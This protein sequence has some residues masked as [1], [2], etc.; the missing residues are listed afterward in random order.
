M[1]LFDEAK[2]T[3]HLFTANTSYVCRIL[4]SGHLGHV[5]YG[6][7][8]ADPVDP[9]ALEI[10]HRI[11]V[12][13][14]IVYDEADRS[15]NLNLARLEIS[16]YGKGDYRDPMVH[17]Q[18][19]DGSRITDF[20]VVGHEILADKPSFPGLPE[21]DAGDRG[22]I[23]TLRVEVF[24]P[25]A[26][27]AIDL[28]YAVFE[29]AD[30]IVRRIVVRNAS[31]EPATI[32]K[33]LSA[34]VD[35]P[36]GD[37]ELVTLDGAWIRERH[38]HDRTLRPGIVKIDSKRG[39]SSADH[40]PFVAVK[41]PYTTEDAGDCYGF[42][43]VYS[44][45]FEAT[46]EV[47]PH[48]LLRTMIGINSFDFEWRLEPGASFLTPE[49]VLTYSAEGMTRLSQNL[50]TVV[51][52]HLVNPAWRKKER[53]I[54]ANNWEATFFDFNER[55][56]MRLARLAKK[57][58]VELFVLD[59]GWFGRRDDDTTS[60]GDWDAD[61]RKL[62]G[63]VAGLA[64]RI[65][66]LG[67]SFG[68][69]VEPEM[70]SPDSDLFRAHPDWAIRHPARPASLGRHQLVLDLTRPEVR[71]HLYAKLCALFD[72]ANVAYCKW[73][74]NRSLSDVF[75]GG[76]DAS[77]QGEFWHRYVL[78]LYE[79]LERLTSRYPGILFES[80]ASGGNRFDL[81][82]LRYMPQT[83]TSDDTDGIE[84]LYIQYGTSMAYP[85]STMGAHVSA[86]PNAQTIRSTPL[87]TRFNTAIFGLLGYELDF[88]KLSRFDR[89]VIRRQIAFYKEHRRLLQFGRF[90]RLKSPF[91]GNDCLWMSVAEDGRE[92][93]VGLYQVLAKPN[94]PAER[95]PVAGLTEDAE[96]RIENR[97]QYF[98]LRTFGDLARHALP[99]RLPAKGVLFH[100]LA[101]HYLMP[102]ET[103]DLTVGGDVLKNLGFVPKQR[104]IGSG[105]NADVRLMGDFGSRVYHLKAL[106]RTTPR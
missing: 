5:Y 58:G 17:F 73:D 104:F 98:N 92:A 88:T 10:A 61:R 76:L 53:P 99:I 30:A 67:L 65:N 29:Q 12:G 33:C 3:F 24:D 47:N 2:K 83:W 84:R 43:L 18:L 81:G 16:S 44:G 64:K 20:K 35:F 82:M 85:P 28:Y 4:P 87:E 90:Y 9:A 72:G 39:V 54:L 34:G 80:C 40:N 66:R 49:A 41:R 37:Y 78:G 69:W 26:G 45:N 86:V 46:A 96:Y 60:L 59:D 48:G 95:V 21:T 103:E 14:Q 7:R 8:L 38:V 62:P 36:A 94:G 22:P 77:H 100:L 25:V 13:S 51:N 19:S 56:I 31:S 97:R 101:N 50:H 75:S 32:R 70:V 27:L 93:V 63:G 91:T 6:A 55:R 23:P 1:I 15:F 57:A 89:A 106:E 11:E 68:I 42:A 71:D 74:M 79:L 105:Y 52:D 102:A